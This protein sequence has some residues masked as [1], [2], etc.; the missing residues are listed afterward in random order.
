MLKDGDRILVCLSG[1]SASLSLLHALRQFARARGLHI[2][3]GAVSLGTSGVDPRALMLYLRDL[4]IKYIFDHLGTNIFLND[5]VGF[6]IFLKHIFTAPVESLRNKLYSIARQNSY[7]VLALGNSLDKL[8][9]D[10]LMSVLYKGRM[11]ATQAHCYN[12]DG[13]L[14][15]IRPFIYVREKLLEDFSI[16]KDLPT[17][18]SKLFTK[19]PDAANSVL[20]VQEATNPAVYENIKN[21]LRPL[22]AQR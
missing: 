18:P 17:R 22:M 2:D 16:A 10:F 11:L 14:R 4:N 19:P 7:N 6:I 20:K 13:D 21:A 3:L 5:A 9:D 12:R 8:A 15:V 1:S